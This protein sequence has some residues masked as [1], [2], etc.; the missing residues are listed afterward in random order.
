MLQDF[1][2]AVALMETQLRLR[3]IEQESHRCNRW[4]ATIRGIQP[5]SGLN[6]GI[7]YKHCL[8]FYCAVTAFNPPKAGCGVVNAF[9]YSN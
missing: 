6:K 8:G 2:F 7:T 3:R 4:L 1:F 5:R 9:G